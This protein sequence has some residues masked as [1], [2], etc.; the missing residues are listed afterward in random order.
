ML[1]ALLDIVVPVF[2]VVAL[3]ALYGSRR[4]GAELAF[5]NR[6]NIELFTPALVFSALVK[7]PLALGEHLPL[8]LAGALVIL[9]PGLMLALCPIR[10]LS[11]PARVLPAMFRNTGNLGIPLMLLAFGERQLGAIVILFVLSN[12]LHFSVGLAILGGRDKDARWLWL[13]SPMLWAAAA[14]LLCANLGVTLP[15]FVVTSASLLGQISVPLMLFALGIRLLDGEWEDLGMA[16]G[17][18]LL[19]LLVGALSLCLV[20]WLLPLKS[21]WLPLL[22]VTV[23]LPPAVLN[24]MLCEQYD[25]QPHK[26]AS[27]VLGGNA[28]SVLVIPLAIWVAL[29]LA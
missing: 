22:L 26:V 29:H 15:A 2:A 5:V 24:Y 10:G 6:A 27:I 19:Y 13:R 8:L 4:P 16:L 1:S 12:L 23:A 14:G 28:L 11:R 17:I 9:L 25:C 20:W 18:N 3:G 21:E 7:Y